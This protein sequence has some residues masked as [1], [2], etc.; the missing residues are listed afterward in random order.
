M[1]V[2]HDFFPA[3]I[4]VVPPNIVDDYKT[5]STNVKTQEGARYLERVRIVIGQDTTSLLVLI[6]ADSHEGPR[7]IFSD[8]VTELNWSGSKSNDSQLIT[9]QGKIVAF[10]YVQGC[11][12]GSRLRSWSPYRTM[13]SIKDPVE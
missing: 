6:A 11:N 1:K 5:V 13:D 4:V 10:R 12:C 7:L 9:R 2:L 3:V 8:R